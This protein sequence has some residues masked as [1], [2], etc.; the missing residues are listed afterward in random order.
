MYIIKNAYK[1]ITRNKGRN[2]LIAIVILVITIATSISLLINKS[3]SA[4]VESYKS[5]NP[6]EVSL[7]L[8][9]RNLKDAKDEEKESF[10]AI[11]SEII[12]NLGT[13]EYVKD[14][15]YTNEVSLSS[16]ITSIT[17]EDI[18][19]PSGDV[20]AERPN[21][22]KHNTNI[23]DFR[24]TGYSD[25]SYIESFITGTSKIVEGE[26]F[27]KDSEE[28]V[29][30]IS[31][32][33]KE[34]NDLEVGDTITFYMPT[35]EEVTYEIKIVGI[36]E[37][38]SDESD[39]T[40]MNLMNSGNQIYTNIETVNKILEDS[41][42]SLMQNRYE[43]IFYLNNRDDFS[44]FEEEV[45]EKGL[46]TYYALQTNED[47]LDASLAPIKNVSSFSLTFL[48]IVLVLGCIIL[49]V[50][51]MI[52]IR[53][54]KYEIGVLRAIGMSKTKISL[55]LFVEIFIVSIVSLLLGIGI[56]STCSQPITDVILENEISSYENETKKVEENFGRDSFNREGFMNNKM[57][58]GEAVNYIDTLKVSMDIKTVI[59]IILIGL[60]LTEL[61][62]LVCVMSIN[63]YEPNKI[64]QN[65]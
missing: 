29:G 2:F 18:L 35:N 22:M 50:I 31:L 30:V 61:S 37:N 56:G 20:G 45:K 33:L 49:S 38:T 9:T 23:G 60:I 58:K 36:Y 13:S 57:A 64:L 3:G 15:Y 10:E 46:S 7:S 55:Q 4:L 65:R 12:S 51:N 53:E 19:K 17:N 39:F 6:L 27:S 43:A 16:D 48:I 62:G 24:I 25:A 1:S 11:D 52:H 34:A 14:Y 32:D 54:R 26:M 47:E 5:S 63:K 8:D 28:N 41:E 59:Q 42:T 40:G 21:D 44:S